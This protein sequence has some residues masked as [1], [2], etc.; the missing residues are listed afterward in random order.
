MQQGIESIPSSKQQRRPLPSLLYLAF[1]NIGDPEDEGSMTHHH[2]SKIQK[3]EINQSAATTFAFSSVLILLLLRVIRRMKA[4]QK[5]ESENQN[6]IRPTHLDRSRNIYIPRLDL[7][8]LA[9]GWGE[10]ERGG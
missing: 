2:S 5:Q 3:S 7:H 8:T 1:F 4:A 6:L 10:G 9:R